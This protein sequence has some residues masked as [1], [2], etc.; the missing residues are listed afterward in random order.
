VELYLH[1]PYVFVA[2]FLIKYRISFMAWYLVKHRGNFTFYPIHATYPIHRVL[3][4][5]IRYELCIAMMFCVQVV[6][7]RVYP[8]VSGL[9][10]WSENCKWYSFLLLGALVSL[11]C[12]S[13]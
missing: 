2:W 1:S 11:F 13:V 10:T 6:C 3:N 12:E 9:A 4:F 8:K 7:M 5:P